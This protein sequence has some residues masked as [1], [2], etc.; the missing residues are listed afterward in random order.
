MDG[1]N[2]IRIKPDVGVGA[3]EKCGGGGGH[4][5]VIDLEKPATS[6]DDVEFVS[7]AGF[8]NQSQDRCY[9]SAENCSTAGSSQLCV[10]RNASRVSPGE[11]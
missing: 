6:D 10:E 8:G 11:F 5:Y 3:R 1:R 4:R 9:A 7:Y 2:S